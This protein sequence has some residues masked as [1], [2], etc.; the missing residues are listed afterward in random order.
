MCPHVTNKITSILSAAAWP[1]GVL[2]EAVVGS[3]GNI[4]FSVTERESAKVRGG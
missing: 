3:R 4:C 1:G 2:E